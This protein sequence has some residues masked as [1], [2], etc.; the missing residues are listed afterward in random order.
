[1]GGKK[2]SYN[3]VDV[4]VAARAE[5]F[6][7]V[8]QASWAG[9]SDWEGSDDLYADLESVF[10]LIGQ[11]YVRDEYGHEAGCEPMFEIPAGPI[12]WRYVTDRWRLYDCDRP[13]GIRLTA[14]AVMQKRIARNVGIR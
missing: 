5:M 12:E 10:A 11:M 9:R 4:H 7:T 6:A 1:M 13:T 8:W 2:L 14:R 3:H